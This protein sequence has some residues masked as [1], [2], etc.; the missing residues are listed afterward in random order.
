MPGQG[1]RFQIGS[2]W[3][4]RIR[5]DRVVTRQPRY[6]QGLVRPHLCGQAS[7]CSPPFC[8][9][10]RLHQAPGRR[11][12]QWP[13]RSAPDPV[14]TGPVRHATLRTLHRRNRQRRGAKSNV[15]AHHICSV[16]KSLPPARSN[17]FA[18]GAAG[19]ANHDRMHPRD[20]TNSS[21]TTVGAS[22]NASIWVTP[23]TADAL[24]QEIH[25]AYRRLTQVACGRRPIVSHPRVP[26]GH[27]APVTLE[28]E[29]GLPDQQR[30][31][32]WIASTDGHKVRSPTRLLT[33]SLG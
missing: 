5:G 30:R 10:N 1:F 18:L 2:C 28:P 29:I 11:L 32:T 22:E 33:V 24:E 14:K 8:T 21:M 3:S 4:V 27:T 7:S 19:T 15:R 20:K 17:H 12:V 23:M 13:V 16:P 31:D 25:S 9:A 26:G 6:G